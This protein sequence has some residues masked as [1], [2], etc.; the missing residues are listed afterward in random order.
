MSPT[1]YQTAPP[2]DI[3]ENRASHSGFCDG[4]AIIPARRFDVKDPCQRRV[5][6]VYFGALSVLLG[7]GIIER[8]GTTTRARALVA[9]AMSPAGHDRVPIRA[10]GTVWHESFFAMCSNMSRISPQRTRC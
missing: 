4:G 7:G 2:R 1:S 5:G 3:G 8:P 9:T 10:Y 6:G